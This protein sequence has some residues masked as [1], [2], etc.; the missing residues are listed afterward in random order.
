MNTYT[1]IK[2]QNS[3]H[4]SKDIYSLLILINSTFLLIIEC[5]SHSFYHGK[6]KIKDKTI[7]G[8]KV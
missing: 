2:L 4:D 7:L 8:F 6:F 3:T 1:T 5:K